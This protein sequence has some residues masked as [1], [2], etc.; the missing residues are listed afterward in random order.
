MGVLY[1]IYDALVSINV[2]NEK[3]RAVIDAMEQEMLAQLVTRSEFGAEMKLIRLEMSSRFELLSKDILAVARDVQVV[4]GH[5]AS[6]K[7]GIGPQI[8]AEL[9][10]F[11]TALSKRL[12]RTTISVVSAIVGVAT[13]ILG[14]L[15]YFL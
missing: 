9:A 7:E 12:M 11:E 14:S 5:L 4:G 8:K 13:L 3:A 10:I 2:P 15:Q 1:S 6:V